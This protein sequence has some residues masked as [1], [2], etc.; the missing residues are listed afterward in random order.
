M[1]DTR[2]IDGCSGARAAARSDETNND[3][4]DDE[5]YKYNVP[6]AC[7]A[8]MPMRDGSASGMASGRSHVYM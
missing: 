2:Q 7:H 4:R 3:R 1:G 5:L 6:G 8:T